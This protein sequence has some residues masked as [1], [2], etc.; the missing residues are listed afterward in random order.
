MAFTRG[1]L[2][3]CRA[4]S[5]IAGIVLLQQDNASYGKTSGVRLE[6]DWPSRIEMREHWGLHNGVVELSKL[7][8][9]GWSR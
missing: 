8:D 1:C 7:L 5:I 2:D 3:V 9:H 6:I 4:I